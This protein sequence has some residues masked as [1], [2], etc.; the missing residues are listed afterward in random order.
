MPTLTRNTA[1]IIAAIL[2]LAL[3]GGM[4]IRTST[5]FFTADTDIRGVD[6]SVT[7]LPATNVWSGEV[8]NQIS[9][10]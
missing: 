7:S 2:A 4:V 3:V 6:N 9:I 1:N 10:I 8:R 5:A